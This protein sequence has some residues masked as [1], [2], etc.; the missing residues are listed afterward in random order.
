MTDW[1]LWQD[2]RNAATPSTQLAGVQRAP[3]DKTH[4]CSCTWCT[5]FRFLAMPVYASGRGLSVGPQSLNFYTYC[6]PWIR[7]A[8]KNT[9]DDVFESFVDGICSFVG[10]YYGRLGIATG[11]AILLTR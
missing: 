11:T 9:F 5:S 4:F 6:R 10:A 8:G 1:R 2:R 3:P 7:T